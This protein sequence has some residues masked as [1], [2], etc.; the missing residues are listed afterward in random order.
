VRLQFVDL[1]PGDPRL[2]AEVLPVLGEL[3]SELDA[4]A[5]AE[6]YAEGHPQGLR[7]TAAY[8]SQGRCVGV[9]GWRIMA[10]TVARRKLYVDDL[11]TA[12]SARS[13][14]V[15]SAL[16]AELTRRASEAG[17]TAIDLDSAVHR[18]GAHRFYFREGL[19]IISFHFGR[20]LSEP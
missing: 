19:Q 16:L 7:F 5:F 11:V 6:I 17:C 2:E 9:A 4:A 18:T 10:T 3:R 12:S 14:G 20:Q 8:D 15:G 1:E 13:L